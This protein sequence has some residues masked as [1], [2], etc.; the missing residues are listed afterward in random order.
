VTASG[1]TLDLTGAVS[2]GVT[3]LAIAD[4]AN[5]DLKINSNAT[6][7]PVTIDTA[8]KTLEIAV[9]RSVTINAAQ[10]VSLGNIQI[11]GGATLAASGGITLGSGSNNGFLQG[12]GTVTANLV[13]GGASTGSTV[14]AVG[15]GTL[16][17]QGAID[18][19]LVLAVSSAAAN[20]LKIDSDATIGAV[21]I[22]SS[23]QTLQVGAGHSVTI[24]A[25]QT[26][27]SGTLRIDGALTD[28]SGITLSAGTLSGAGSVSAST[29]ITGKGTVSLGLSTANA[30][31]ASGGTLDLTGAIATGASAPLLA[32]A[33]ASA[34]V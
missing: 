10:T 32:I 24:N 7:A 31:T 3:S 5:S 29:A 12:L 22:S 1:G 34:S 13:R 19:A 17:L 25:A 18:S 16:D 15:G 27:A 28:A 20:T 11:D 8:N 26:V 6:I 21:S 33:T 2:A 30:V 14:T 9:G 4:V 23:N